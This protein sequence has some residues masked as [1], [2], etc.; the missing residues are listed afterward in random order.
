MDAIDIWIGAGLGFLGTVI[1]L[2][3][4]R[5]K[6]RTETEKLIAETEEIRIKAQHDLQEQLNKLREQNASLFGQRDVERLEKDR[7]RLEL[8]R[9]REDIELIRREL[10]V[11]RQRNVMLSSELDVQR[12]NNQ[13]KRKQIESLNYLLAEQQ[14]AID[15]YGVEIGVIKKQT[16]QLPARNER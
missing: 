2:L 12:S 3:A 11:E 6:S 1:T 9:L 7:L 5:R 15:R 14:K 13:E 8:N 16:G 4:T 10:F